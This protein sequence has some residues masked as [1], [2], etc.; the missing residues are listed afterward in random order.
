MFVELTGIGTAA[1]CAIVAYMSGSLRFTVP[2]TGAQNASSPFAL[3]FAAAV[4]VVWLIDV[5][6]FP[7]PVRPAAD[8]EEPVFP[9][10]R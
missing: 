3:S 10:R 4:L 6:S 2:S 9:S 1:S 8:A 5:A 7:S